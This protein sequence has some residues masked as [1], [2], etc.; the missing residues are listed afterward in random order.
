MRTISI[1]CPHNLNKKYIAEILISEF[2]Y[3]KF[4]TNQFS[5]IMIEPNK[6]ITI[7]LCSRK[8]EIMYSEFEGIRDVINFIVDFGGKERLM[9]KTYDWRE[10]MN[11]FQLLNEKEC[12]YI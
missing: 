8:I 2:G 12:I 3:A 4:K 10:R 5:V 9:I 1:I 11:A 7:K 6:E